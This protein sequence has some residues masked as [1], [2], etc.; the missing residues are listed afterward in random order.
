MNAPYTIAIQWL[1]F[2]PFKPFVIV[3][4][5]VH[6]QHCTRSNNTNKVRCHGYDLSLEAGSAIDFI[7]EQEVKKQDGTN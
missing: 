1:G 4:I 7:L 3:A 2:K 6:Y 5:L